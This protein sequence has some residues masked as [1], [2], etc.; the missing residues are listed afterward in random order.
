MKIEIIK[1]HHE[2][3]IK[4]FNVTEIEG[5]KNDVFIGFTTIP[6]NMTYEESIKSSIES[7][8]QKNEYPFNVNN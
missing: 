2:D 6:N 3:Y 8:R 7:R 5:T 1:K 4:C